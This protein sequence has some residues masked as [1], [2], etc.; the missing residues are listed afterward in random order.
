[1]I[2]EYYADDR[3]DA[4]RAP[5]VARLDAEAERVAVRAM[6]VTAPL[7]FRSERE[8]RGSGTRT[9]LPRL[10]TISLII[11]Q[12]PRPRWRSR[13]PARVTGGSHDF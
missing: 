10:T 2:S 5:E 12:S 7:A 9:G 3:G 1:L 8:E 6:S 11:G 4:R 13:R